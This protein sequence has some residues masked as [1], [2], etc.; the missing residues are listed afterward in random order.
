MTPDKAAEGGDR[1]SAKRRKKISSGAEHTKSEQ[2]LNLEAAD[3]SQPDCHPAPQ[4]DTKTPAATVP[5]N[6]VPATTIKDEDKTGAAEVNVGRQWIPQFTTG[7]R[8]QV[9]WEVVN[10]AGVA[11]TR[12]W[13][14][15]FRGES[16][17]D[18]KGRRISTIRYDPHAEFEATDCHVVFTTE[19]HLWD[20]D[21]ES[22]M[23]W[24]V[25][26]EGWTEDQDEQ[27]TMEDVLRDQAH[28][29]QREGASVGIHDLA[30]QAFT[31]MPMEKQRQVAVQY[32]A[33]STNFREKLARLREERG[34]G[35]KITD[36]DIRKIM[37]DIRACGIRLNTSDLPI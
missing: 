16:G 9:Q 5:V 15:E 14:C 33:F 1:P 26:P 18:Q 12:W 36:A 23:H 32:Q 10:D 31:K 17:L 6:D 20:V 35:C 34:V 8:L 24:R 19:H 29:E 7:T 3:C 25:E 13:G 11:Q 21:Y 2:E 22:E 28:T 4:P 27:Y 30:V 37:A